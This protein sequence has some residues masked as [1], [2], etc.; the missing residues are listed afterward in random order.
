MNIFDVVNELAVFGSTL[1]MMA[2][3]TIWYSSLL[4]GTLWMN[5]VQ[6]TE[7]RMNLGLPDMIRNM[8]ITFICYF[9]GLFL[10][11]Y[12]I[13]VAPVLNTPVS[14]LALYMFIFGSVLCAPAVVWEQRNLRYYFITIGFLA[15]FIFGGAYML[16]LWPW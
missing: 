13:A 7:E 15:F 1:F 3:S 6:L 11:G 9:T 4:F 2:L 10:V 12:M 8:A 5:A 14:T 16:V